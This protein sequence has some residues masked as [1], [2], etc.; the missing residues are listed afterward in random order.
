MD[1]CIQIGILVYKYG[2]S[3]TNGDTWVQ[4]WILGVQIWL[5]WYGYGYLGTNMGAQLQ[6]WILW[7]KYGYFG[8]IETKG[9]LSENSSERNTTL[10]VCNV[11]SVL[12]V[13]QNCVSWYEDITQDLQTLYGEQD[14]SNVCNGSQVKINGEIYSPIL[15]AQIST[16]INNII[17]LYD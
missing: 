9:Y 15:D 7:W 8:C 17:F 12:E 2:Y 14:N 1:T 5:L 6:V 3:G 16:A 4:I 11:T 10:V 13:I